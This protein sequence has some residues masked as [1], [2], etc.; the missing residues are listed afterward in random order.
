MEQFI[1]PVAGV[2]VLVGSLYVPSNQIDARILSRNGPGV[3]RHLVI[4]LHLSLLEL[5]VLDSIH[6]YTPLVPLE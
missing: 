1:I 3:K 5:A 2:Q 4:H 6:L